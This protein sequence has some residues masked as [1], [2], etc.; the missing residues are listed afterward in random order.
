MDQREEILL[1]EKNFETLKDLRDQKEY[2]NNYKLIKDCKS[3]K[4]Y[5]D[6]I[7]EKNHTLELA[8]WIE[9]LKN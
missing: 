4:N 6:L 1:K 5:S 3:K 7:D 2:F 8:N 9:Y